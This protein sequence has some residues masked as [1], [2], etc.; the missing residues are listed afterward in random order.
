MFHLLLIKLN[1][2][3]IRGMVPSELNLVLIRL[4]QYWLKRG[5]VSTG[6]TLTGMYTVRICGTS[7]SPRVPVLKFGSNRC[8]VLS[9]YKIIFQFVCRLNL[10]TLV[11]APP[12][13][14]LLGNF[15][16]EYNRDIA[17]V[18]PFRLFIEV[19]TEQL[20]YSLF[21]ELPKRLG[22]EN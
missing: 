17:A 3:L 4:K 9:T 22:F 10:H 7:T 12:T 15:V 20:S 5:Q 16:R 19:L 8:R 13:I 18:W 11:F 2:Y 6:I 14:P 1:W 21:L